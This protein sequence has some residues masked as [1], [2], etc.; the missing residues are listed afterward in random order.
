MGCDHTIRY[1][2]LS[3]GSQRR[4]IVPDEND[5]PT[6]L[7]FS[8]DGRLIA[9]SGHRDSSI[10]LFDALT[11]QPKRSLAGQGGPRS[12]TTGLTFTPDSKTL[13][14]STADG[15]TVLWDI[16][17]GKAESAYQIRTPRG[18]GIS[19]SFNPKNRRLASINGNGT[20]FLIDLNARRPEPVVPYHR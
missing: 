13:A 20:A 15:E 18:S 5:D 7:S 1:W 9:T 4:E 11:G 6:I 2:D 12:V 10:K 16:A 3:D 8:P 14:A 19:V 17:S